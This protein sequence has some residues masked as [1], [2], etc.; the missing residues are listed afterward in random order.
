MR[1]VATVPEPA[2]DRDKKRIA[3][4]PDD[5]ER[6]R[7]AAATTGFNEFFTVVSSAAVP[8]GM[9]IVLQSEAEFDRELETIGEKLHA[10][11]LETMQRDVETLRARFRYE[12]EMR[13]F[14]KADTGLEWQPSFGVVTGL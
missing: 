2:S 14:Y 9:A 3:C 4:T 5:Y 12:A 11:L 6:L 1:E 13:L 10:E 7:N 8:P